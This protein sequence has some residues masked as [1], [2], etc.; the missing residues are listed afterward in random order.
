MIETE[1]LIIRP[2]SYHELIKHAESP[3]ELAKELGL[4]A[5]KSL[6]DKE[7]KEAIINDLLPNMTDPDKDP[8]FYTMWIVIEKTEK[9]II[10]GICFHGEPDDQ[11]E[12]EIG[13]GTD[14]EYRNRGY[15]SES[16]EGL[17]GWLREGRK[18][19]VIKGETDSLNFSSIRV[20]EKNGFELFEQNDHSKV[21]KLELKKTLQ[22]KGEIIK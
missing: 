12:V 2:L 13:Y 11:G 1:R 16:I 6:L 14:T 5:S 10:G 22:Q 9:A 15:M 20:L 3:Y 18:V 19:K 7:V 17:V 4:T 21:L 8:L